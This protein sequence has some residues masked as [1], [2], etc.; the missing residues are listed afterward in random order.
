MT[1]LLDSAIIRGIGRIK[2]KPHQTRSCNLPASQHLRMVY[3]VLSYLCL[4]YLKFQKVISH[5]SSVEGKNEGRQLL[6][7]MQTYEGPRPNGA[8]PVYFSIAQR[9]QNS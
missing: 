5:L 7:N 8:L 6:Q 2:Y 4:P 1:R 9:G 3:S